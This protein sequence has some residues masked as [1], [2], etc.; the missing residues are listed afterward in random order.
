MTKYPLHELVTIKQKKLDEAEKVLKEKKEILQNEEKKLK[1]VE[2][3]RDEVKEHREDKLAQ[4]RNELDTGTT[5]PKIQQMKSYLKVVEE[6]QRQKEQKVQDQK[7]VVAT[8]EK[9]V[10]AARQEMLKRQQ[11]VEKLKTHR[12]EWDKEVK[13]EIEY[14]ET[15]E[16]DEMGVSIH[17]RRKRKKQ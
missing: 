13:A 11:D 12:K 6:K 16:T 2:K 15:L 9:A 10:D 14:K 7:K 5:S 8:A 1:E 4:L 17:H 3:E